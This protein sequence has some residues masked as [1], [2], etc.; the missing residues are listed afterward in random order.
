MAH[1]QSLEALLKDIK[2]NDKLLGS[3]LLL[4]SGDFRQTFPVISLSTYPDKINACLKSSL[5]MG[6]LLQVH[7]NT[8]CIKLQKD[9]C[10]IIDSQNTL[11]DHIFSDVHTQYANLKWLAERAILAAKNV[12]VNGLNLKIQQL[13]PGDLVSHLQLKIGSPI[14]LFC[15]LNPPRQCNGTRLFIKKLMKNII[16]A[17]I[18]NGKLQGENLLLPR[19]PMIPTDVPIEF[20]RILNSPLDWHSL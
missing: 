20:K 5:P 1:K 15:N 17:I 6:K 14:I 2:N 13:L 10:T 18:L 7:E 4:L 11:I 9:Y 16:E 19:I 3:T 8:G 12:D